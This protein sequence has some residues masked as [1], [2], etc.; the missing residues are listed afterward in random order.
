L[1]RL[2]L[3][4]VLSACHRAPA[5][6]R[7]FAQGGRIG[8]AAKTE[9]GN[10][11]QNNLDYFAIVE[12]E[13][14]FLVAGGNPQSRV[15]ATREI[16]QVFEKILKQSHEDSM[17]CPADGLAGVL[18]CIVKN[19]NAGLHQRGGRAGVVMA[20]VDGGDLVLAHVGSER[21]WHIQQGRIEKLTHDS[22]K[23]LGEAA[24]VENEEI[25]LPLLTGDEVLL[26]SHGLALEEKKL[27]E[28]VTAA[29]EDLEG[30]AAKLVSAGGPEDATVV[31]LQFRPKK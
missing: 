26:A 7:P 24:T 15:D 8:Y 11:R 16:N 10:L 20:I 6:P 22:T 2:L 19:A 3:I 25:R 14:A 4:A 12:G 17:P 28:V 29:G 18:A 13:Q 31:L 21:A 1:R 30:A 5:P 9:A 27:L 23:L